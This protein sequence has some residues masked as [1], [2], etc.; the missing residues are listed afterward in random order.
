MWRAPV[1][2]RR[3][4]IADV[5]PAGPPLVLATHP[6]SELAA[7]EQIVEAADAVPSVA[8]GFEADAMLAAIVRLA[9]IGCQQVDEL[10]RAV[11]LE[12]GRELHLAR[13]VTEIVQE[14][15]RIVAPVIAQREYGVVAGVEHLEVA[16]ADLRHF[17]AHADHALGP[18]ERRV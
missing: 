8:I 18:I 5:C 1:T 2:K 6:R 14:Q 15:H 13:R 11:P 9:V 7:L 16:P 17:L 3:A 12:A 10:I 4:C